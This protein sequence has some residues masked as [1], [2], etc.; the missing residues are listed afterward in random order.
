MSFT[1]QQKRGLYW[2]LAI[3]AMVV[4]TGV[5]WAQI[6]HALTQCFSPF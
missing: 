3:L 1:L 4:L 6:A 2:A 5:A